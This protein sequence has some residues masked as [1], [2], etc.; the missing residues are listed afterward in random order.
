MAKAVVC[1]ALIVTLLSGV[2]SAQQ[3]LLLIVAKKIIGPMS[4]NLASDLV[5]NKLRSMVCLPDSSLRAQYPQVLPYLDCEDYA[6][7]GI[8][9][10]PGPIKISIV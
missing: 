6:G 4:V 3:G 8:C 7:H 10:H 9:H 2:A 5:Y 1:F